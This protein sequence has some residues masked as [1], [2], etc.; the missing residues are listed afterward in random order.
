MPCED[1][2]RAGGATTAKIGERD[3]RQTPR[4]CHP[5][6]TDSRGPRTPRAIAMTDAATSAAHLVTDK[7]V[8]ATRRAG[9]LYVAVCGAQVLA[10]SLT[11]PERG[12]CQSCAKGVR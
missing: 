6:D 2:A 12:Q 1:Q 9:S 7:S 3:G 5:V 8:A 4:C 11:T 10:A